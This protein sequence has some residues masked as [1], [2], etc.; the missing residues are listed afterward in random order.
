MYSHFACSCGLRLHQ[1]Y[2]ETLEQQGKTK[3]TT[4]SQ[5][6]ASQQ[7]QHKS[8]TL[9]QQWKEQEHGQ[10][11]DHVPEGVIGAVDVSSLFLQ[12]IADEFGR[13][14]H[15]Q[16]HVEA[17]RC[18]LRCPTGS[19][20]C[21]LLFVA[22]YLHSITMLHSSRRDQGAFRLNKIQPRKVSSP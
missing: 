9:V 3:T 17:Q 14:I 11:R 22:R 18:F 15:Y 4:G 19:S 16:Q 21:P 8:Q 6:H 13:I 2:A 1:H 12:H 10:G 5:H 7:R 20:K